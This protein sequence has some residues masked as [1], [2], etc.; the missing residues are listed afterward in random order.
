M[1]GPNLQRNR[2]RA[3]SYKLCTSNPVKWTEKKEYYKRN[4]LGISSLVYIT[5]GN[6]PPSVRPSI[7][8]CI[9]SIYISVSISFYI[10]LYLS[11]S[12]SS[13]IKYKLYTCY[14]IYV[15]L[16][17]YL[18]VCLSVCL[19]AC[20]PVCL[21][22]CPSIQLSIYRSLAGS[23]QPPPAPSLLEVAFIPAWLAHFHHNT[24]VDAW[25][26]KTFHNML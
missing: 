22:V 24:W 14:M 11:L 5:L 20:V 16:S 3:H 21:S 6:I 12:L 25:E 19:P 7:Y 15:C 10:Y 18:S 13:F 23:P 1:S 17:I 4:D 2:Q 9:I 26:V 8:L